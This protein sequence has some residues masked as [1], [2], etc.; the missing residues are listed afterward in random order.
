MS[1]ERFGL[2]YNICL[3]A[4]GVGL[5][6]ADVDSI[7]FFGVT[8][9]AATFTLTIATGNTLAQAATNGYTAVTGFAPIVHY[10]TN[11]DAG[12]GTGVWS[13]K[14]ANNS[15]GIVYGGTAGGTGSNVVPYTSTIAT[16][17]AVAFFL[18]ASMVPAGYNYVKCTAVNANVIAVSCPDVERAPYLLPAMSS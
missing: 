16:T 13:N 17:T 3:V 4:S 7:G 9:G 14:V 10:Y 18:L 11:A 1:M 15:T 12:V 6:I 5:R 8:S 2:D